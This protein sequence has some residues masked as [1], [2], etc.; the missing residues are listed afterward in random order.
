[1]NLNPGEVVSP[2]DV[3]PTGT[4]REIARKAANEQDPEKVLELA[5][6]LIRALDSESNNRMADVATRQNAVT[7]S[8]A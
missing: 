8:S 6:E 2:A 4:W 7:D 1:M 3:E 5:R